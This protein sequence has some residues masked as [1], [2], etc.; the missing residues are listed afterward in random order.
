MEVRKTVIILKSVTVTPVRIAV[1]IAN[2]TA[3][4]A[5]STCPTEMSESGMTQY[6]N[7]YPSSLN[8]PVLNIMIK[9]I[10]VIE[11]RLKPST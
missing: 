9:S 7:A 4:N 5:F 10:P 2:L 8:E 3:C 11:I 6:L 1:T